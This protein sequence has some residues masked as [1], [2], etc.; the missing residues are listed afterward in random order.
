[1]DDFGRRL[2]VSVDAQGW[3]GHD[4][5]RQFAIQ[6]ALVTVLDLAAEQAGLDR[7]SWIRQPS[8]DGEL[9]LLPD[10]EPEPV[11]VDAFVRE[12]SVALA[13]HNHDLVPA[14][15]LRLRMAVHH[16]VATRSDN[17]FVGQGVVLVSRLL[18]SDPLRNAL[19]AAP[20]KALA[21][22]LSTRVFDDVVAQRRTALSIQD[23][24][25]VAIQVKET[26]GHAWLRVPG[27]DVHTLDVSG[28]PPRA[29]DQA[30]SAASPHSASEPLAASSGPTVHTEVNAG[31]FTAGQAIFGIVNH[32]RNV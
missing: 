10:T 5:R 16:G 11:V 14:A 18:E 3:G 26:A 31:S 2:L 29:P 15:W 21:V 9:S 7:S 6:R 13:D 20:D 22:V 30:P 19:A 1:M 24:R 17:G 4:E 23:F 8:G 12:L 25:K 28:V 32:A 27:A